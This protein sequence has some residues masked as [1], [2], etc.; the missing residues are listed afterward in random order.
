MT[1]YLDPTPALD[2]D[3]PDV[4]AY[5]K[6]NHGP[7]DDPVKIAVS[8]YYGVRDDIRY[9]PYSIEMSVQALK[10]STT[11]RTRRAWCVPKAALLAACCRVFKIP[12]RLGYADVRNH[13]S[14]KRMRAVMKT[15]IFHWH[16]YTD[17]FLN[18]QWVKATPAFNIE[19]CEKFSIKVLSFDGT[20]DS[21]YQ[22]FDL[23]GN[24]HMEYL[25]YR[26]EFADI[27]I[28]RMR[29]Y[30]IRKY[31]SDLFLKEGD[32]DKEVNEESRKN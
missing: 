12:A 14:T 6:Q 29:D 22:P 9:D 21:I 28:D 3:H 25:R 32:F 10:A 31:R 13:L 23:K 20:R 8:L 27:P 17:I 24:R 1:P 26:G 30:F 11:I 15:D 16:G 7:S 4:I 18:D 5:A 19:L 2:A